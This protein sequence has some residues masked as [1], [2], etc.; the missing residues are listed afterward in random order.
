[1]NQ[2][3]TPMMQPDLFASDKTNRDEQMLAMWMAGRNLTAIAV[4]F[5]INENRAAHEMNRI[6]NER[7]NQQK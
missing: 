4:A 2:T 3:T 7:A 6:L 5:G 1:M